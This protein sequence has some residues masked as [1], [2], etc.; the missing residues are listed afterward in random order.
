MQRM[1]LAGDSIKALAAR[2]E[3]PIQKLEAFLRENPPKRR[4]AARAALREKGKE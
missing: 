3:I 4:D 2:Y 1:F